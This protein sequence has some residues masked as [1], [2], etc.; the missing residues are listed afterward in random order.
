METTP[1]TSTMTTPGD[2]GIHIERIF[3]APRECLWRATVEADLV[4]RWWGRGHSVDVVR[5]EAERGGRWRF[6]EHTPEGTTEGFEGRYSEVVP[7]ERAVQTFE[8]DGMP[9]HPS[10]QTAV[11]E[12]MGDGRTKL[13]VDV[14]FFTPEER[15]SMLASGMKGGMDQSYEALDRLLAD[16]C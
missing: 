16:I 4:A 6:V 9:G 7:P 8:W 1:R 2:R 14:L 15:D 12:D 5:L 10:I 11:F 3:D 13:M